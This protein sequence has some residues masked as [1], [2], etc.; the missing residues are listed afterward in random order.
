MHEFT[1]ILRPTKHHQGDELNYHSRAFL[2]QRCFPAEA[3]S[4][5]DL[6]ETKLSLHFKQWVANVEQIL[7]ELLPFPFFFSA[8][9][10][11]I[12]LIPPLSHGYKLGNLLNF[13]IPCSH[14]FT[15]L[16]SRNVT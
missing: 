3:V 14:E 9:L 2:K 11:R 7:V 6:H 15:L 13:L 8:S 10:L 1:P 4:S 16:V 12:A 5:S